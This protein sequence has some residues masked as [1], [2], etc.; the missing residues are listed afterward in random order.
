MPK[1]YS[2]RM[3]NP[4][5]KNLIMPRLLKKAYSSFKSVDQHQDNREHI[6]E[7]LMP[8]VYLFAKYTSLEEHLLG[9]LAF[10]DAEEARPREYDSM[11]PEQVLY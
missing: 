4:L 9:M 2:N 11:E 1:E 6:S 8:Y 10:L 7:A 3:K 5:Q